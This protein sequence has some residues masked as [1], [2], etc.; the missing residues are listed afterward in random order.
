MGF[1]PK[2]RLKKAKKTHKVEAK[3]H[4]QFC[5]SHQK[6]NHGIQTLPIPNTFRFFFF[7]NGTMRFVCEPG[8]SAMS[9]LPEEPERHT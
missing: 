8:I 4:T 3:E 9:F 1:G 2:Y 6:R 5:I 7:T